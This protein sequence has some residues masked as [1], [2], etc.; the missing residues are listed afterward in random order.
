MKKS[1]QKWR[2]IKTSPYARNETVAITIRNRLG[3]KSISLPRITD[4]KR[5]A[6]FPGL[7]GW[8]KKIAR[9]VPQCKYYVEPF[10]GAAKVYQELSGFGYDKAVLNDKSKFVTTWLRKEFPDAIVTGVDF[11]TCIKKWDSKNTF[12]LFDYPW[13]KSFYDQKFSAF[14]RNKVTDYDEEVFNLCKNLKGKFIITTRKENIRMKDSD[15][16]NKL[17]KSVYVVSGK[18][19][20]VLLTTNLD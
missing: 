10:A 4:K 9:M 2:G 18:Y 6:G 15:F 1:K 11:V 5:W 13:N 19:P 8:A 16:K 17:L 7:S 20:R 3:Q 14:N 12:F